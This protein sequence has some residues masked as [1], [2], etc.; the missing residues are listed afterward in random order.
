MSNPYLGEIRLFAGNFA[1]VN[2][3]LCD[4]RMLAIAN[5]TALFTAIGTT[6]GGDGE[7]TFGLPDLR[8]RAAIHQGQGL[9]LPYYPIG[10]TAGTEFVTLTWAEMG[11]HAHA[12]LVAGSPG[13]QQSPVAGQ[14]VLSTVGP[15][16]P[17]PISAW[18]PAGTAPQVTLG[19]QMTSPAGG[20]QAHGNIQPTTALTYIICVTGIF[21]PQN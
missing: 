5:Y 16:S 17:A 1:P 10:Q 21:P 15:N 9:Q 13:D 8:G 6:Y 12:V 19:S 2:F 4:G 3:M 14:S 20:S 18:V 11:P 7:T